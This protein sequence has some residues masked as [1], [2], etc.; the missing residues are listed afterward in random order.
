MVVRKEIVNIIIV[1]VMNK[2]IIDF[3]LNLERLLRLKNFLEIGVVFRGN[4]L[5]KLF[6]SFLR[7]FLF[8]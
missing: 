1:L 3:F 8:F 5:S 7:N 4:F 2:I 6:F